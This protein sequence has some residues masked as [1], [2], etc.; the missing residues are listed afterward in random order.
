MTMCAEFLDGFVKAAT[1]IIRPVAALCIGGEANLHGGTPDE[2]ASSA[3]LVSW[4]MGHPV[5]GSLRWQLFLLIFK[6]ELPG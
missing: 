4:K 5:E 6:A 1:A 2:S 3:L